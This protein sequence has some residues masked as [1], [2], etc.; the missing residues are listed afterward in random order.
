MVF[1]SCFYQAKHNGAVLSTTRCNGNHKILP[2]YYAFLK[3]IAIKMTNRLECGKIIINNK[4]VSGWKTG[5]L[6]DGGL[7]YGCNTSIKKENEL[8]VFY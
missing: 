1:F 3:P 2:A 8:S 4:I 5:I 6:Y 7:V